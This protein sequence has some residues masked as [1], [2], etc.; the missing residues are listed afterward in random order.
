MSLSQILAELPAFTVAER[1]LLVRRA[2]E[3]DDPPLTAS[4]EDLIRS[5]LADHER[6]PSAAVSF[7]AMKEKLRTAFP[8]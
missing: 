2:I 8:A 1:Q 4:D 7:E 5:R 3:L 6:D